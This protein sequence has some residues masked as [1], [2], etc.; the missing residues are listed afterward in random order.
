MT[1]TLKLW[2]LAFVGLLVMRGLLLMQGAVPLYLP[3]MMVLA[4]GVTA[5]ALV[6]A[7][8]LLL[9]TPWLIAFYA[10]LIALIYHAAGMH[11]EI[12]GSF[13]R[14]AHILQAMDSE[15]L[16]S[17]LS[18]HFFGYFPLY[19]LTATAW[20][21]A[22][23]DRAESK[24][25]RRGLP[26]VP[27]AM[28]LLGML[29]GYYAAT[30]SP[31]Y[32]INNPL[33]ATGVQVPGAF[34]RAT[35]RDEETM[36]VVDDADTDPVFFLRDQ[37]GQAHSGRPNILLVMVEGLSGAYLPSVA[38][39]HG[40]HADLALPELDRH[41]Q[42]H[43]FQLFPN[44]VAMQ[45]QTNRGSY[46]IICGDYPR[47]TTSVPKMTLIASAGE[48][49]EC[50]P[51][52]LQNAGYRTAY[53]QAASL[54][55]MNKDV[56][57][58]LA[59]YQAVIGR[60]A[61]EVTGVPS[62]GWGPDDAPFFDAVAEQLAELDAGDTPWFAT[63]LNVATHHPFT[64]E[65]EDLV[66]EALLTRRTHAFE[67][68]TDALGG[69]LDTLQAQGVLDNTFVVITSDEAGGH[70]EEGE[71]D[72]P[73]RSNFGV[74]ALRMPSQGRWP[75]LAP[76]E[77]LVAHMDVAV[78]VLD[79]L[80]LDEAGNMIGSSM[81]NNPRRRPRGL[82]FG[83]TYSAQSYFLYDH[84]ELLACD[85][86]LL[87]CQQWAFD[88]TRMFGTLQASEIAPRLDLAARNRIVSEASLIRD[89]G[90]ASDDRYRVAPGTITRRR[91]YHGRQNL[92][93][94]E[95]ELLEVTVEAQALPGGRSADYEGDLWV[96]MRDRGN[97]DLLAERAIRV[98]GVYPL[99]TTLVMPP[100]VRA[101]SI[102]VNLHW[103]PVNDDDELAIRSLD[104]RRKPTTSPLPAEGVVRPEVIPPE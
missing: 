17:T 87:R 86:T 85:E 6:L 39:H 44:T 1:G 15:F 65:D 7:R 3:G 24:T 79:L 50:L 42:D 84:G 63:V 71:S 78:T 29:L 22:L 95:A 47:I 53:I 43:G 72:K 82:L 10:P 48:P 23:T 56:F 92:S 77:T 99:T 83:D 32:L 13:F 69:L 97:G 2:A 64:P 68:L 21:F 102:D 60:E 16:S 33:M 46:S 100:P 80:D 34:W 36:L 31:T 8:R 26:P 52:T 70:G 35:A 45:R 4:D 103:E 9:P 66:G 59:G 93:V 30:P 88:P 38:E 57:M 14:L 101:A 11:A 28:V 55:F 49:V 62:E 75:A 61:L 76:A 81:L 19:L 18:W 40:V 37:P 27:A 67:Q 91:A 90:V 12:H 89:A 104:V 20:L 5:L 51:R 25:L 96:V 73:M 58:P 94:A 98:Q 54:A 74:M 41:L